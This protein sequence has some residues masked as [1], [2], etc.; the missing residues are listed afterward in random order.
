MQDISSAVDLCPNIDP[1]AAKFSG[2]L[3]DTYHGVADV[4]ARQRV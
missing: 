4:P 3:V 1:K 2:L